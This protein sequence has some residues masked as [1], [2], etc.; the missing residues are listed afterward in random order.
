MV[1]GTHNFG[2]IPTAAL[3]SLALYCLPIHAQPS[4]P[5]LL[6][7]NNDASA[8]PVKDNWYLSSYSAALYQPPSTD[9]SKPFDL[10]LINGGYQGKL[11]N[12]L[13]VFVEAGFTQPQQASEPL[14]IQGYNMS[15]GLS[16]QPSHSWEVSTQLRQISWSNSDLQDL[17]LGLAGRYKLNERLSLKASYDLLTTESQSNQLSLGVGFNF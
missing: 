5:T 17:Q 11:N 9:N 1:K 8:S 12:K 13:S 7:N 16:Y 10:W 3:C 15:T 14:T 2:F 4:A 6:I